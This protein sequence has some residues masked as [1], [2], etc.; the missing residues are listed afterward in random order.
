M[1]SKMMLVDIMEIICNAIVQK[2]SLQCDQIENHFGMSYE[3][4]YLPCTT[5]IHD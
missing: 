1:D 2:E 3:L 5:D 4:Q